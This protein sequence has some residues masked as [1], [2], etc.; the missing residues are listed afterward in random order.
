[1][2]LEL[3]EKILTALRL[4]DFSPRPMLI[5]TASTQPPKDL[6]DKIKAQGESQILDLEVDQDRA[7]TSSL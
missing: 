5:A 6:V 1:M 2:L 3:Q 4:E 7:R